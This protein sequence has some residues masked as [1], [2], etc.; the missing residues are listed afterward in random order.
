MKIVDQIE[1]HDSVA[2]VRG[3]AGI[4]SILLRPAYVHHW[5]GDGRSWSGTG[6]TQ[7]GTI[8]VMSGHASGQIQSPMG[9]SSGWLRIGESTFDGLIPAPFTAEGAVIARID[10]TDGTTV[11]ITGDAVQIE[12]VGP[13]QD[14]ENL[15]KKWAPTDGSA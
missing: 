8:T 4:I 12:L 2:E 13:P 10:F 3:D 7:D 14:V 1:L 11:T 9:I 15:P 5:E 6:R